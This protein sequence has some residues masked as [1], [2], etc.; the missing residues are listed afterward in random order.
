MVDGGFVDEHGFYQV[1]ADALG[2]EFVDLTDREIA[3]RFCN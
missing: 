1:I 2:T 3:P